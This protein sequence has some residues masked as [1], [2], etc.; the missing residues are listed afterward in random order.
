M[1]SAL[2]TL[3]LCLDAE[4][5]DS[6]S[7]RSKVLHLRAWGSFAA[8]HLTLLHE[9]VSDVNDAAKQEMW[10]GRIHTF[11]WDHFNVGRDLGK[12]KYCAILGVVP[13][14]SGAEIKRAFRDKAKL[15]HPD[16]NKS[17]GA[18][19]RFRTIKEAEEKRHTMSHITSHTNALPFDELIRGFGQSLRDR[20][21]S[22]MDDQRYDMMEKLLFELRN[23]NIL[24]DLV[25]PR[26][27]TDDISS[28]VFALVKGFVAKS[29]VEVD[30]HWSE[31][32]YKDLND[33]ITSLRSMERHFK[34]YTEIFPISWDNGIRVDIESEI[35]ALGEKARA[36][37][38]DHAKAEAKQGDFRRCFIQMGF[39]L[40][41]LPSFK[42]HTKSVM[43][44]VLE[45][46]LNTS[47]GYWYLFE[48][49]LALQKGDD[50]STDEE[51][52]VAQMIVNEFSHFKEVLVMVWNEE[53][54]QKPADEVV[55]HIKGDVY[56]TSTQTAHLLSITIGCLTALWLTRE[57]TNRWWLITSNQTL[58]YEFL[59]TIH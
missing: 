52:R 56:V 42:S 1:E 25:V 51:N 55:M 24:D 12:L 40:T 54:L 49:G 41:E 26:L 48:L 19:E 14:A 33:V 3:K 16:K 2:S 43:S 32:N 58:T 5:L 39:V 31:R 15:I 29:R 47:W 17:K 38:Q 44:C 35:D 27:S 8:D 7:L 11:C 9:E 36:C 45:S 6:A 20:A 37:L 53:V 21:Q 46:C 18:N 10:L 23:M 59:C 13:S 50:A 28:S 4:I 34:S 30:T 57:S 22:F